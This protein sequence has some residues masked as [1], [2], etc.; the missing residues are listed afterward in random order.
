MTTSFDLDEIERRVSRASPNDRAYERPMNWDE[1]DAMI[2]AI[3]EL[4]AEN[5]RLALLN[6]ALR[7]QRDSAHTAL[8]PFAKLAIWIKRNRTH[9][10]TTGDEVQIENWPYT[11]SVGELMVARAALGEPQ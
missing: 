8:K 1:A 7:M 6:E 11:L 4:R 2:A 5:A 3:R 9:R 10:Y